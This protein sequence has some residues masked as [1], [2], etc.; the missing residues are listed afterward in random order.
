MDFLNREFPGKLRPAEVPLLVDT[1]RSAVN[2]SQEIVVL[3]QHSDRLQ[4]L[5]DF[6]EAA[7]KLSFQEYLTLSKSETGL[8]LETIRAQFFPEAAP[9]EFGN[10][11]E[12]YLK[13]SSAKITEIIHSLN[14]DDYQGLVESSLDIIFQISPTGKLFYVSPSIEET[15]G[16]SPSELIGQPFTSVVNKAEVHKFFL[17]LSQFFREKKLADFQANLIHKNGNLIPCEINGKLIQKNNRYIGQG[18][19]RDIRDR[20]VTEESLRAAEF[21]FREVWERSND[22]MRIVN[23]HGIVTM[24]NQ[25]YAN[26]VEL[27]REAIEGKL[28]TSVY[29][30]ENRKGLLLRFFERFRL[31]LFPP[32]YEEALEIWNEKCKHFEITTSM[33]KTIENKKLLLSILR[34]ITARKLQ[35]NEIKRKDQ[36]LQGVSEASLALLATDNFEDAVNSALKILGTA[37]DIDRV[38]IF[39]NAENPD[40]RLPDLY[41]LYEWAAQSELAQI[42]HFQTEIISYTRFAS[43]KLYDRLKNGEIVSFNLSDMPESQQSVFIDRSIKSILLAPLFIDNSFWGFIGFDACKSLRIWSDNDKSV[44]A[45]I[46]ASIGG[47]IQRNNASSELKRKNIELDQ[48][49]VQAEAATK[50]KSEFLALMS[51]EIRTP[52]NGVIGMTGLLMDSNL[53]AEQREFAETIRISGEQLLVIINDILDFSKIESDKMELEKQPFE[54]RECIE[55]TL[56]LLGSKAAEKGI[57]LLYLIKDN[58]PPWVVGDITRL[59]QILTNLIGNAIKF[60]SNG[61]VFV[62]VNAKQLN[63]KCY[64][65]E[66]SVRDSGIGI[67]DEKVTKL[68]QPFSQVDSSTT[69]IYGGTGL[70]LVISK[71]L[72]ELMGGKMWVNSQLGKGST[73][74]FTL[75]A[76]SSPMA[77]QVSTT[78]ILPDLHD[79]NVL[80]VDDNPTNRKIL[81]LEVESWSMKPTLYGL[82]M[83][84][85]DELAKPDSPVFDLAILDY[86]M[87]EMD[88]MS[89]TRKIRAMES[90]KQFPIIILTSLGRKED[91]AVLA[92][93]NIKK[94]LNKPIKHSQL[95]ESIVSV[96]STTPVQ[97]QRPERHPTLDSSLGERLPLR[98]LVAEDNAIN[99]RVAIRMLER[100]G[101]RADVA[102]NGIETLDAMKVIPYDVVFMD[103]HM[104]EMD[105][106]EATRLLHQ[107]Y[108]PEDRP[109]IIAMTANAMQGDRE[110]CIAVGMDDYVPKPVRIEDFQA[111]IERWG[112]KIASQKGNIIE[113]LQKKKHDYKILDESKISFLRDLQSEDDII[114]FIELI[115]MYMRETPKMLDQLKT[116]VNENN[117]KQIAFLA[118]KLKGSSLT[119]G[120]IPIADLTQTLE[121]ECKNGYSEKL[122]YIAREVQDLFDL[123]IKDLN[124]LKTKYL[125]AIP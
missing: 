3:Q 42:D 25:A 16:Y 26:L 79:K 64:E 89:L 98:I 113:Q 88:G 54:I 77:A 46:A 62:A 84:A 50:A 78:N 68:F 8:L 33:L 56:D 96:L 106:L 19:I 49:L 125:K 12:K 74:S 7:A 2:R 123:S 109:V 35:D 80:I 101:Y 107:F 45:A 69:R 60:T 29:K 90:V 39:C 75:Q 37:A 112:T 1:F 122:S 11:L 6:A 117:S 124:Q 116:A 87:P 9:L 71:R 5:H 67:S 81:Q 63:G 92:E 47:L 48:A 110:D 66:F 102:A 99:Q 72:A 86:Q 41:E 93:L 14:Y 104:P 100:L 38:Y 10:N 114:F 28:Y 103:V 95:F 76:E 52:M 85:L 18:T 57:D 34:D 43:I 53:D 21:L 30:K 115:D 61:E 23:E 13:A 15:L 24:C 4:F 91:P 83:E 120:V 59:R 111:V 51:H 73:F 108:E 40:K 118:H 32:F 70:G 94:F 119:L 31:D 20:K 58:T 82:P 36:L 105:G 27:N 17:A 55:D 97:F 44:I 121:S 22:G 65:L